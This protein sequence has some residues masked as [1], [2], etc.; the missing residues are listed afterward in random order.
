MEIIIK[1][2]K[3]KQISS[4]SRGFQPVKT[5]LILIFNQNKTGWDSRVQSKHPGKAAGG[6]YCRKENGNGCIKR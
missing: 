1:V 4:A 6:N 2:N 5:L 3:L